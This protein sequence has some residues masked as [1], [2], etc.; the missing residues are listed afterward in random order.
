M[1]LKHFST[2]YKRLATGLALLKIHLAVYFKGRCYV[3]FLVEY[4]KS[5]RC[6]TIG[7]DVVCKLN[8]NE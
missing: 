1:E 6:V 7:Y 8:N 5:N 4:T 2:L 3:K